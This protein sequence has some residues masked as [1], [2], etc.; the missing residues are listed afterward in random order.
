[1]D[2]RQINHIKTLH[3]SVL[4]YI[5]FINFQYQACFLYFSASE[6][7]AILGEDLSKFLW[8]L[9]GHINLLCHRQPY[10]LETLQTTAY[11]LIT[12]YL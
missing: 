5:Y 12:S 4:F 3:T 1:M 10:S 11:G 8:V 2:Y 6:L 9:N 7:L